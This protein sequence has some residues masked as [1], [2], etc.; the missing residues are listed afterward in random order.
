MRS[1]N[2]VGIFRTLLTRC[3]LL[4]VDPANLTA[5]FAALSSGLGLPPDLNAGG[6]FGLWNYNPTPPKTTLKIRVLD[7][8]WRRWLPVLSEHLVSVQIVASDRLSDP[9][10]SRNSDFFKKISGKTFTITPPG[11][12]ML[13][14]CLGVMSCSD[15]HKLTWTPLYEWGNRDHIFQKST[16]NYWMTIWIGINPQES[17]Q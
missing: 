13:P 3:L 15:S 10:N 9:K 17:S 2:D 4:D 6:Q 14:S 5:R 1:P 16:D 11:D 12:V 7:K 8:R